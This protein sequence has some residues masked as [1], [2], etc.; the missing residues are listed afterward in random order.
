M[1][2]PNHLDVV[3]QVRRELV[4]AGVLPNGFSQNECQRFAVVNE[5]AK[6]LRARGEKAGL[7]RKAS[8][9]GCERDGAIYTSDVVAYADTGEIL[10]IMGGG[11]ID[12]VQTDSK[13]TWNV[14]SYVPPYEEVIQRW[15]LPF[16]SEIDPF[17]APTPQPTPHARVYPGDD[18]GWQIGRVLDADYKRAGR[19]SLDAGST[20]W[21]FRTAW[22]VA[23]GEAVES[24]IARHRQEWCAILGVPVI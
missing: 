14:P 1:S 19:S 5:V 2:H 10:D 3:Q 23:N 7:Y 6:R 18:I 22:D 12:G 9:S 15:R 4:A 16:D 17:P 11:E 13:P 24:A 21:S 20:V 8:G